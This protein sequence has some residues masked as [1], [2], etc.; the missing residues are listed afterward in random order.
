MPLFVMLSGYFSKNLPL[1]KIN[2]QAV[3]LLETY[4]VMAISMAVMMGYD[5]RFVLVPSLSCWYLLSL[6]CWRYMLYW[7]VEKRKCTQQSLLVWSVLLMLL[8]FFLPIKHYLGI[9]SL[10]RTC[11]F[12][13][14]FV[15]G[16]CLTEQH[17]LQ[18]RNNTYCKLSFSIMT[19][20]MLLFVIANSSRQ[21][22]VLE[23][24]RDTL[25]SLVDQFEWSYFQTFIYKSLVILLSLTISCSLIALKHFPTIF[26]KYGRYTLSFFFLQGI[27]IHK[28]VMV[29][30]A[31]LFLELLVS[32]AVI[33]LGGAICDKLSWVMNPISTYVK[34]K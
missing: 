21:L 30:P 2:K 9:I 18:L 19:I 28:F 14:F 3:T 23:F 25:F 15:I 11:Q 1:Y 34:R 5:L 12:F 31:N 26:E 10:M 4:I 29:L 16:Y 32:I 7:F 17:I 8:T 22:H 33:I 6:V 27:I 24:H 20:V 13:F